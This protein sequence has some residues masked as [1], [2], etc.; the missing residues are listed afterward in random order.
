MSSFTVAGIVIGFG[1]TD[2]SVLE[3]KQTT[4]SVDVFQPYVDN[5]TISIT[6][7]TLDEFW[8]SYAPSRNVTPTIQTRIDAITD[9]AEC[10][11]IR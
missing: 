8:R 5:I 7:L 2:R 10:K 11:G 9:A 1:E 3:N 6:P 4:F